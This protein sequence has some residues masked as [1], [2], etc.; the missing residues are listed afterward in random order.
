MS[1]QR[2]LGLGLATSLAVLS[3]VAISYRVGLTIGRRSLSK[4][5]TTSSA[6]FD[7]GYV[8]PPLPPSITNLLDNTRLCFMASQQDSEPHLCLMNFTYHHEEEILI[9]CT[10]RDTKKF[11]QLVENPSVAILIHDQVTS[12]KCSCT[13]N[14]RVEIIEGG[15]KQD[16]KYRGIHL[17]K[18]PDYKQFIEGEGIAVF[19]VKLEKGR[20]C[21]LRD[22][23]THWPAPEGK[24]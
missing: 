17:F 18:N 6:P 2:G 14:G 23:V 9:L 1:M 3:T 7:T 20:L 15:S 4:S 10:R 8:V 22:K 16:S 5:I 13:L 24:K 12:P 21:D 19:L 11:L